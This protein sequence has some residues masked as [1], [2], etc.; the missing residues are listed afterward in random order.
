MKDSFDPAGDNAREI[1]PRLHS[2]WGRTPASKLRRIVV[3]ANN[4]GNAA[5]E[6][7]DDVVT[8]P[9]IKGQ[10]QNLHSFPI[11][12]QSAGGPPGDAGPCEERLRG[13][14]ANL[15]LSSGYPGT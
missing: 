5:L 10:M 6:A 13:F 11:H 15:L 3:D 7:V 1:A 12:E 9:E 8:Q 14:I 4:V 2:F